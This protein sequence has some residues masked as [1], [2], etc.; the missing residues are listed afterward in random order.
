MRKYRCEEFLS[1]FETFAMFRCGR[2]GS[3]DNAVSGTIL[4][5]TLNDNSVKEIP[6]TVSSIKK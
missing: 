6:N 3:L 1:N 2:E 4:P 5:N